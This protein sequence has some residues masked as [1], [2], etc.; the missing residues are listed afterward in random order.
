MAETIGSSDVI[1]AAK[2]LTT[3]AVMAAV[4]LKIAGATY[5]EIADKLN[6]TS[7]AAARAAVEQGLADAYDAKDTASLRRITSARL[8]SLWRLAWE[9]AQRDEIEVW[10][11]RDGEA[12]PVME[13]N[14]E[15]AAYI[16]LSMDIASRYAKLHGLDAPT[17]ISVSP[18]AIELEETV[19]KLVAVAKRGQ[20]SEADI[21]ADEE[22]IEGVEVGAEDQPDA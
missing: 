22:I 15:R 19:A 14:P 17:Q 13:R 9:E 6:Y 12:Y 8:E 2:K 3:R 7:P 5:E 11:T 20:H 1:V 10:K 18:G 16:R 4:S 21:F